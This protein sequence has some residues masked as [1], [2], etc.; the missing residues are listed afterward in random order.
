MAVAL[1]QYRLY[2]LQVHDLHDA[3]H[4]MI[5][6]D[7]VNV[8]LGARAVIEGRIDTLF[9]VS[10][11]LPWLRAT[12]GAQ[13]PFHD[14]SYPPHYLFVVAPF[15]LL[16]YPV[17]YLLWFV[18]GLCVL[19]GT[20][21]SMRLP[22]PPWLIV[23]A[24]APVALVNLLYGQNGP[25][26]GALLL[27]G[28]WWRDARPW[29]A[30]ALFAA[31]TVKPQLGLLVPVVLV[32][33]GNWRTIAWTV[34]WTALLVAASVLAFGWQAW[35]D[36]IVITSPLQMQIMTEGIGFFVNMMQTP[37]MA[38]R[39]LGLDTTG[40]AILHL[41][42]AVPALGLTAWAAWRLRAT[43]LRVGTVSVAAIA[44]LIVS[45]YAMSYDMTVLAGAVLIWLALCRSRIGVGRGLL[46]AGAIVLP[47][48]GPYVSALGAPVGPPFLFVL[49][50]VVA[51][52]L[53]SQRHDNGQDH[54]V[55]HS[56]TPA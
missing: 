45:P 55:T 53:W 22:L 35:R 43:S 44:T 28:L 4:Y 19:G 26:V 6:R 37:F 52:D 33:Q 12:F 56:A 50:A 1:N 42:L 38:G 30:G 51:R 10:T 39:V 17:A 3:N 16:P 34:T 23:A 54:F 24:L 27:G 31:L 20:L 21:A 5:G 2:L 15:G 41:V 49:C 29:L 40:A 47:V 8:W 48:V 13:L 18:A 9:D 32:L 46:A 7:F 11:Y 36:Y 25:I 14:W